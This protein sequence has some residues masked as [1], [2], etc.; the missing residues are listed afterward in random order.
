M[1]VGVWGSFEVGEHIPAEMSD[2]YRDN[3]ARFGGDILMS[4]AVPGQAGIGH[5]NCQTNDWVIEEMRKRGYKINWP[6]TQRLRLV[7]QD[8]HCTWFRNTLMYFNTSV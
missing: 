6:E 8:C 7:M 5:I 3:L 4:W 2:A 1:G